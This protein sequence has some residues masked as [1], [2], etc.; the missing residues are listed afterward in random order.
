MMPLT[1]DQVAEEAMRLPTT[2]RSQL[3]ERLVESL[4]LAEGNEIQ[5]L[6][7]AEA[8][9]R[10]DEIRS[11]RVQPIPGEQVLAE[12]RRMVGR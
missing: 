4:Y 10:R 3:A 9:R 8:I 5:E 7:A 11:G 1:L 12:V 6:W 2:A